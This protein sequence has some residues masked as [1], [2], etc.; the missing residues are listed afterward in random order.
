MPVGAQYVD[1]DFSP[2][3]LMI[4]QSLAP[5]TWVASA[6]G[7]ST[8]GAPSDADYLVLTANARLTAEQVHGAVSV[9]STHHTAFV[10]ADHDALPNAHHAAVTLDADADV[11]LGLTGQ[12]LSLD[13]QLANVVLSGPA[14]G[15]AVDPTFRALV[16]A[17]IPAAITR[18]SE[19]GGFSPTGHHTAFVQADHD[20][21][22]SPHHAT[23]HGPAQHTEGTA[24]RVVYL[25]ALGDETELI[26]GASGTFLRSNGAASAPDFA[27]PATGA[28]NIKET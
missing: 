6:G 4:L 3:L 14:S 27:T 2:P 26:L 23:A 17:D 10:Q 20:A 21:L 8:Q 5:D 28:A 13:T 16:D 22:P 1:T 19:H 18:D 9:I 12:A 25:N 15:G 11:L 24:W 7:G